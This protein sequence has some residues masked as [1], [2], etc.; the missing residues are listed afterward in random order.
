MSCCARVG[1][2]RKRRRD[3]TREVGG[4]E[5]RRQG[6]AKERGEEDRG[7]RQMLAG[8]DE[9]LIK[10]RRVSERDGEKYGVGFVGRWFCDV[11]ACDTRENE[12]CGWLKMM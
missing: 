3:E 8:E 6:G 1:E 2:C 7:R 10:R 9:N 12:S 5:D 11:R 4:R